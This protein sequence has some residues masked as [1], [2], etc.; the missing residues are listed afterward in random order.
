MF[1]SIDCGNTNIVFCVNKQ[2]NNGFEILKSW[3]VSSSILTTSDEFFSYI[4][5]FLSTFNLETSQIKGIILASVVPEITENL[6]KMFDNYFSCK[7]FI[8]GE[9]NTELDLTIN[10]ENPKEAGADRIVN[11]Y[12]VKVLRITP[13]IVIDFGTA[14]TFDIINKNGDYEGGIIAPGVNNSIDTLYQST[15][16]LP[17]IELK[18]LYNEKKTLVGKNTVSAIESGIYWGY[19]CMIGG[20]INK[21]K[22]QYRN[23]TVIA[24]G[25]LGALF[26]SELDTIDLLKKDLTMYGLGHIYLYNLN[27]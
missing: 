13:S 16:R 24:T 15:S 2:S 22:N 5:Q 4:Y 14:T 12:A 8:V 6:K 21:L 1:L 10:I 25:G 20:L 11:A 18:K 27:R 9:S 3:R 26:E 23:S 17:K 7:V 19:V